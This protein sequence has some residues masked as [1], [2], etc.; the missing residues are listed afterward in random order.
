MSCLEFPGAIFVGIYDDGQTH[1]LARSVRLNI[2]EDSIIVELDNGEINCDK[3]RQVHVSQIKS[4]NSVM[5]HDTSF[6]CFFSVRCRYQTLKAAYH[7]IPVESRTILIKEVETLCRDAGIV[8][9]QE[10]LNCGSDS[11]YQVTDA[12]VSVSVDVFAKKTQKYHGPL[13]ER[14]IRDSFLRFFTASL[15]GYERYLVVPDADFLTSGNDWFDSSKFVAA[16]SPSFAPFLMA[17]V[18]TQL[19]QSFVQRR[20]EASDVHCVLFDECLAE[21]HS[22]KVP[23]GR[24]AGQVSSQVEGDDDSKLQMDYDLL[25]DQCATEPDLCLD[26]DESSFLAQSDVNKNDGNENDTAT[27]ASSGYA[28]SVI[29]D[30]PSLDKET[31][32]AINASGD[33]VTCPS[34]ANLPPNARYSYIVDGNGVFP[35]VFDRNKFFPME[36]DVLE[37]ESLE[38]RASILTRSEREREDAV[39]M[40]NL[41]VSKRGTQKQH[42]CLWQVAKFMVS[43]I[44]SSVNPSLAIGERLTA[45]FFIATKGSQFFG[46][47]ILCV[48][49]QLSQPDLSVGEKSKILL[50]SLG[51]LRTLRSHRRIVADEAAYR[52]LIVACGRCG[53]DRRTELTKLYGLMRMDG[54]F[55]NAVT[56][57]CYTRA[58]AEGYSNVRSVDGSE[59][60]GMHVIVSSG[61]SPS[62][63]KGLDLEVLD[64]NLSILE[65]SGV[66]WKS[67]GNA[68][69]QA[70]ETHQKME[71]GKPP[72][73]S[74]SKAFDTANTHKSTKA[75]RSWLPVNC[76]S[77]FIP[78]FRTK[79]YPDPN[80]IRLFALWSRASCCKSCGYIA[81]DEEIQAGWDVIDNT[82][83]S[84]HSVACPR[85]MGIIIP[86]I[87]YKEMSIGQLMESEVTEN[88]CDDLDVSGLTQ[89]A[90]P[91]EMPPQL[92]SSIMGGRVSSSTVQHAQAGFVAYLS[93]TKL[94]SMLEDL[95]LKYGEDAL[96]RDKLRVMNPEIFFN[97]WWYSA[98]FSLPLP[99]AV[100]SLPVGE[101]SDVRDY[102]N[103][104][105]YSFS[106]RDYC[107]FASWD[108]TVAL[109]GCRSAAKA[110]LAAQTLASKSDRF[111][112]EKLFDNPYTDNPLLSFFNF[113][114]YAQ[115]D[116]DHP[117]FSE[118]ECHFSLWFVIDI[119]FRVPRLISN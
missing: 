70:D 29:S 71:H 9:G 110:V 1:G 86:F 49:S 33:I 93:P 17:I 54:I 112:R 39:R 31:P 65:E 99:L 56:L 61:N 27:Q 96:N 109:Y 101:D 100:R 77:S 108:K 20:T 106:C 48:P 12:T 58:I 81:L 23:Y 44:S 104:P 45:E 88:S 52:A 119:F 83:G 115:G 72:T 94:R 40:F 21:H 46:A 55:M 63:K 90:Y 107:A 53:T 76:S 78:H 8:P 82:H 30:A 57:G 80:E 111:L 50:R 43:N 67:G 69:A 19:F 105:D 85:C 98:R 102:D 28:E 34:T 73:I 84:L 42:S 51:A 2:P 35:A 59:K 5:Y 3:N 74:P 113:Q 6:P 95:S 41:T 62:M 60:I 10:P 16:A 103:E 116:W 22:S 75:K 15:A 14:A 97:L 32:F 87:G 7:I 18:E 114:T 38:A 89:D 11:A 118:S 24:L 36:P 25:V 4:R 13:D 117:D 91:Q 26:D 64:N 37:I 68:D 47:Y 79:N 92:E 66:R